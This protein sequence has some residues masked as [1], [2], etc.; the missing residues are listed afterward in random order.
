MAAEVVVVVVVAV[1]VTGVIGVIGVTGKAFAEVDDM[2]MIVTALQ[3]RRT[4]SLQF[5]DNWIYPKPSQRL[6]KEDPPILGW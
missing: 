6:G 1:G 2:D 3:A 4:H 5:T